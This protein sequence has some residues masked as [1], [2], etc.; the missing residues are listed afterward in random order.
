ME[1]LNPFL[2]SNFNRMKGF[3]GGLCQEEAGRGGVVEREVKALGRDLEPRGYH[4]GRL[5]ILLADKVTKLV[6]LSMEE[7]ERGREKGRKGAGG[8]GEKE[9]LGVRVERLERARDSLVQ[10]ILVLNEKQALAPPSPGFYYG[11]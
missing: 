2:M 10:N 6:E 3:L 7:L 1:P 9:E 8:E 11:E 5:H 4:L